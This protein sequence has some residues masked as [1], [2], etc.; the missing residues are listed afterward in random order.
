MCNALKGAMYGII[1]RN[2]QTEENMKKKTA[3]NVRAVIELKITPQRKTGFGK[4]AG[5]VSKCAQ[6]DAS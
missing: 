4:I 6:V 5:K 1:H 3:K 2:L